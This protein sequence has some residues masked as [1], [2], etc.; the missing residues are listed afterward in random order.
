MI[1]QM[2]KVN[3]SHCIDL[4]HFPLISL[5]ISAIIGN[6]MNRVTFGFTK[7]TIFLIYD[8]IFLKV[9]TIYIKIKVT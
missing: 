9:N 8:F 1:R 5:F 6:R 2:E 3:A 4:I 7:I